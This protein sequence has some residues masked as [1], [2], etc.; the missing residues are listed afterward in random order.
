MGCFITGIY[1]FCTLVAL[2]RALGFEPVLP[3]GP[4]AV[5]VVVGWIASAFVLADVVRSET[6]NK[7]ERTGWV[8]VLLLVSPLCLG[9]LPYLDVRRGPYQVLEV[10]PCSV[11]T[12]LSGVRAVS[13]Q[14]PVGQLGF[15]DTDAQLVLTREAETASHLLVRFR[16]SHRF[17][18]RARAVDRAQFKL[19]LNGQSVVLSRGGVQESGLLAERPCRAPVIADLGSVARSRELERD[20]D[21]QDERVDSFYFPEILPP[22]LRGATSSTRLLSGMEQGGGKGVSTMESP[23]GRVA[24]QLRCE[25]S[26]T[27]GTTRWLVGSASGTLEIKTGIAPVTYEYSGTQLSVR[28]PQGVSAWVA[29]DEAVRDLELVERSHEFRCLVPNPAGEGPISLRVLGGPPVIVSPRWN[30]TI[31]SGPGTAKSI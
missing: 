11:Y 10:R 31:P 20:I 9:L 13:G 5:Y 19:L 22:R 2:V 7:A 14:D 26:F 30:G 15:S 12:A 17:V 29:H 25:Q 27:Q 1:V 3:T 6:L 18:A 28:W 24:L 21:E 8:V 16:L 23:E 4:L